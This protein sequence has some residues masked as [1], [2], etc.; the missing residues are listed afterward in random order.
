MDQNQ[1]DKS[2]TSEERL[3]KSSKLV[4]LV[5]LIALILAYFFIPAFKNGINS[6]VAAVSSGGLSSV[7]EFIRGYGKQAALISFLLM[8]LQSVVAP[9]PAVLITLANA[10]IFGWV[11]GAILSWSSAMVG[12]ALCFFIAR[13]LGRDAVIKLSSKKSLENIENFFARY[14]KHTILVARLLPFISFDIVSY[15]AGLTSMGFWEFWIATGLGQLPA[16]IVYSYTGGE[17]D[18]GARGIFIFVIA[19]SILAVVV[20]F[21]RKKYNDKHKT[22]F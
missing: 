6:A 17:L 21:I 7:I 4:V 19:I 11:K 18:G 22:D 14:G 12:A 16:T 9:I 20:A 5:P 10:A 2:K 3:D 13:S 15:A 8:L 1:V